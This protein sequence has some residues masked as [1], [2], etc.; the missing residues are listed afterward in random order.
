MLFFRNKVKNNT[1]ILS[2]FAAHSD[3]FQCK[4][5]QTNNTKTVKSQLGIRPALASRRH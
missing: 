2:F 3:H 1:R 4:K 5:S